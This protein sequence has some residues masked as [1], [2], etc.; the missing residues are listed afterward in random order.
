MKVGMVA[1]ILCAHIIL[2]EPPS[3]DSVYGPEHIA[4]VIG[5]HKCR[6]VH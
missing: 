5:M 2:F 1:K 4:I 3:I 6:N